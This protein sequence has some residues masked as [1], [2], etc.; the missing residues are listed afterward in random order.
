MAD[1]V[2]SSLVRLVCD[3]MGTKLMKEF[4]LLSG[5]DKELKKLKG[6]LEMIRDVL[7]DAEVRQ[8][9]D[10][11]LRGWLKKLKDV[12]FE[13]DDLLDDVAIESVKSEN[14]RKNG[15]IGKVCKLSSLPNSVKFKYAIAHRAKGIR[16]KLDE[17]AIERSKFHLQVKMTT[18][19]NREDI[20]IRESS[21]FVDESE[22]YGREEDK[23]KIIDSL[24]NTESKNGLGVVAIV[25]MGGLGKTTIAKLV[26][27][28]ET[29]RNHF[30]QFIW[31][32]VNENF[33]IRRIIKNILE[34]TSTTNFDLSLELLQCKL[35]ERLGGRRFLLVPDDVWN[36]N[37]EKWDNLRGLLTIGAQGSKVIVTSRSTRVASIMGTVEPYILAG[38]SEEDCWLLFERRAFTLATTSDTNSNLVAIGKQIVKKCGGVPLAAKVLGS[39]MRF[40]RKES[41][42]LAIRDNDTWNISIVENEILPSLRLSYVNLPSHLKQCFAYCALFPK[43]ERIWISDLI[44]LW[45]AEGF[46]Q[47]SDNRAELKDVGMGFV[48]ELLSRSL[49]QVGPMYDGETI[50][51]IKIHDLV[52]DMAS[53]VAGEECSTIDTDGI[54]TIKENTRYSSFIWKNSP[55]FGSIYSL[56]IP[57]KLR[58]L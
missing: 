30:D 46:I 31:V 28:N 34:S 54:I 2:A 22:I 25:G 40:K 38:L 36:E 45:I 9:K 10:K 48:E 37:T 20:V 51:C 18:E 6:I 47:S 19:S 17:I 1:V 53:Y 8:E 16:E 32:S 29:V 26:F 4:G 12:A 23:E 15:I 3:K 42:W 49:F 44:Q 41:E 57:T 50:S 58:T 11:A 14:N 7:D 39:L 55:L 52:H 24:V 13:I 33:D 56:G 5:A 43:N 21:S 35:K 27:N